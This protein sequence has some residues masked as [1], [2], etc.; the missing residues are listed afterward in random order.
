MG[1]PAGVGELMDG[2]RGGVHTFSDSRSE[3]FCEQ[4]VVEKFFPVQHIFR[5]SEL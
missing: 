5:G 2:G 4:T 1:H 3:V